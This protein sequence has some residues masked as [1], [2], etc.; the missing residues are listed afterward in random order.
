MDNQ[1]EIQNEFRLVQPKYKPYV[2]DSVVVSRFDENTNTLH[3]SE[4]NDDLFA[5]AFVDTLQQMRDLDMLFYS[6]KPF[7]TRWLGSADDIKLPYFPPYDPAEE[8]ITALFWIS[9]FGDYMYMRKHPNTRLKIQYIPP[10][11]LVRT[12]GAGRFVCIESTEK[13]LNY[14]PEYR[15]H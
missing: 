1:Y 15:E 11:S 10:E 7:R 14:A 6:S 12:S 2:Q 3:V 9:P 4:E 8:E 5:E 13:H